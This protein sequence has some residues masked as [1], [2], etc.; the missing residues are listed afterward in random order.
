[1]VNRNYSKY[2]HPVDLAGVTKII[3][4]NETGKIDDYCNSKI[5]FLNSTLNESSENADKFGINNA[6]DD[7]N[8]RR[9]FFMVM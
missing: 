1:M 7:E 3:D 4:K 9:A 6:F 8:F 5:Q 2:T